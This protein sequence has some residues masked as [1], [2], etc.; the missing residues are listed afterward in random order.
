MSDNNTLLKGGMFFALSSLATLSY[1]FLNEKP[2]KKKK[3]KKRMI[4]I[5]EEP[6]L[7]QTPPNS[8]VN[9]FND[10][11]HSLEKV[12]MTTYP[13]NDKEIVENC[14]N[15]I[16]N[17][18]ETETHTFSSF[19]ELKDIN[20]ATNTEELEFTKIEHH[21]RIYGTPRIDSPPDMQLLK[22]NNRNCFSDMEYDTDESSVIQHSYSDSELLKTKS[23]KENKKI[24]YKLLRRIIK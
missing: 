1:H 22:L 16:V 23:K 12:V 20:S 9:K 7:P 18:V 10:S 6:V 17:K 8:P 19:L 5:K 14:V 3:T 2:K 15:D 13:P 24:L 11:Y 21:T 4:S